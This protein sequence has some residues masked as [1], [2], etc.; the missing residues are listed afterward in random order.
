MADVSNTTKILA[1]K[2]I[3]S[4]E[5]EY[6]HSNFHMFSGHGEWV[7]IEI[8]DKYIMNPII[9]KFGLDSDIMHRGTDPI[10]PLNKWEFSFSKLLYELIDKPHI[11]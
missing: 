5:T 2:K 11:N 3:F 8:N 1:L 6:L 7:E 10:C 9:D 4:E